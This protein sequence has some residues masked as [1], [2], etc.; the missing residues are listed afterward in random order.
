MSRDL[1]VSSSVQKL[2]EDKKEVNVSKKKEKS[3]TFSDQVLIIDNVDDPSSLS[4]TRKIS[5]KLKNSKID[6][7]EFAYPLV[8]GGI[9]LHFEDSQQAQENLDK[10]PGKVFGNKESVHRPRGDSGTKIGYLKNIDPRYSD[11]Q[12][13]NLVEV[14]GCRVSGVRRC[15]HRGSGKPMPVVKL[16]HCSH[17]E[18][19]Q[20]IKIDL[21]L[22]FNGRKAYVEAE[23]KKKVVRCYNCMRFGH[24]G[25]SCLFTVQ[26]ENCGKDHPAS[27]CSS[28]PHC[29]NCRGQ[30][31]A[32]SSTCPVF[33]S[34]LKELQLQNIL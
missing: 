20:T 1:N 31:K 2:H 16:F 15:F 27:E 23:R 14:S 8:K 13:L 30:H 6:K 9:A 3:V 18:L 11:K 21:G 22:K 10:W 12:V 17:E 33:Q 7:V 28:E 25:T 34:K 24:I 4:D 19:L 29:F 32:S 5:E 26:C